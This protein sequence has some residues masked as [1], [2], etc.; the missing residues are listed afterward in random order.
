MEVAISVIM[1][2][3]NMERYLA[4][5]IDSIL[6]QH[7]RDFEFIIVND[8]STDTGPEI[9]SSYLHDSRISLINLSG[10]NGNNIARNVGIR[11]ARGRYICMMD[12]DDI[13]HPH[14]LRIE[15][16][17][18]ESQPDVLAAGTHYS[19][20]G[21]NYKPVK[22]QNYYHIREVLLS[23]NCFLHPSLIIRSDVL[24]SIGGY[25]EEFIYSA[26]YDLMCRLALRGVVVNL[27]ENL[28]HYRLHA[29]QISSAHHAEQLRYAHR[30]RCRYQLALINQLVER[31]DVKSVTLNEVTYSFIGQ[32]I[33][34]FVCGKVYNCEYYEEKGEQM[35]NAAC[36]NIYV[37]D[38][39]SMDEKL[40]AIRN[41]VHYL[42]SNGLAEGDEDEILAEIN[43]IST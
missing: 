4:A 11:Q 41:G 2:V 25:D 1:P 29:Q 36:E 37:S 17:Y 40:L 18:M 24:R 28:M 39:I 5:A 7:F 23:H 30:A 13:A 3:Y 32:A 20:I 10:Q 8:G 33:Y 15:Y 21:S 31:A 34:Y 22:P 6:N 26:D 9:I 27:P 43:E 35:L 19:F 14:R 12:A 42:L 38:V 16:A